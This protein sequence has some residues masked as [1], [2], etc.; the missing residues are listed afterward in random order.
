MAGRHVKSPFWIEESLARAGSLP[1]SPL[2]NLPL[3][4]SAEVQWFDSFSNFGAAPSQRVVAYG[5]AMI[6][7]LMV[8]HGHS[9]GSILVSQRLAKSDPDRFFARLQRLHTEHF[10]VA[11]QAEYLQ[12]L[13]DV[14]LHRR[15]APSTLPIRRVVLSRCNLLDKQLSDLRTTAQELGFEL[16]RD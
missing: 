11:D 1:I 13:C 8:L 12:L 7:L 5:D 2:I 6:G 9:Y 10:D 14:L 15:S 4:E 16:I 3:F